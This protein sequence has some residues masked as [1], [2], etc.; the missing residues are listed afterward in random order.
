MILRAPERFQYPTRKE[1]QYLGEV[2][3]RMRSVHD[4]SELPKL[5]SA[6]GQLIPHEFAACAGFNIESSAVQ[7]GHSNFS[8]EYSHLYA[9][10]GLPVDPAI[11]LLQMTRIGTITSEDSPNLVLPPPIMS[12]KSDFGIKA[13]LSVGVKGV[14]GTC[15]YFAFSNFDEKL[16]GKFRTLMQILAPHF[17]LA[18][19]QA[20]TQSDRQEPYQRARRIGRSPSSFMSA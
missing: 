20:T 6:V 13:C 18:F 12:L 14:L 9:T 2:M 7:V 10:Q 16:L 15:T 3:H 4:K 1:F 8:D 5:S 19:L 11:R 17:H